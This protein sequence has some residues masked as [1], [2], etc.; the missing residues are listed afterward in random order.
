M[1]KILVLL[2]LLLL[3]SAVALECGDTVTQTLTVDADLECPDKGI[4]VSG[5]DLVFDCNK[6]VIK[7]SLSGNGIT[8]SGKGVN[9]LNCEIF[10]FEN[11]IVVQKGYDVLIKDNILR[12][13]LNGVY[14]SE[15]EQV[16]V[17]GN[18]I[19][20]NTNFGVYSFYVLD[21]DYYQNTFEN[22]GIE[23]LHTEGEIQPDKPGDDEPK[24]LPPPIEK[25][26]EEPVEVPEEIEPEFKPITKNLIVE[27]TDELLKQIGIPPWKYK[28]IKDIV[29]VSKKVKILKD[30]MVYEIT[31]TSDRDLKNFN[32]YEYF[33]Q[34]ID[35]KAIT[36]DKAFISIGD[37]LIK[38]EFAEIKKGEGKTVRYTI[39]KE[40]L[41]EIELTPFTLFALESALNPSG[42]LSIRILFGTLLILF[43]FNYYLK[44][45]IHPHL[46]YRLVE[47]GFILLVIF[48]IF[49]NLEL[50]IQ[51][52]ENWFNVGVIGVFTLLMIF[53]VIRD[54]IYYRQ[55]LKAQKK[56]LDV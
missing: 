20:D 38:F 23:V 19:K 27:V 11:G 40:L 22:T 26:F 47:L 6:H 43:I 17:K 7:G 4:M 16:I 46:K 33:P 9:I 10:N 36:S 18:L 24:E 35:T 29:R 55:L 42:L 30:S 39:N 1:K 41:G 31:A 25:D 12:N 5:K 52:S 53:L 8:V 44:K 13:N 2:L 32:L 45:R 15:S 49:W 56:G 54:V 14:V 21:G 50:Q 37:D 51:I 3:P 28:Q 34:K 48:F